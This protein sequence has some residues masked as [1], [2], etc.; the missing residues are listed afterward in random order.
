MF[1]SWM[2]PR[3]IE[4]RKL[5][6][7]SDD[8]GTAVNVQAMV[9][10]NMGEDSGTGVLFTR[11]PSTGA[12]RDGRVPDQRAGRRRGRR[13]SHSDVARQDDG[14]AFERGARGG[15]S[16]RHNL[17]CLWP[18]IRQQL[19]LISA[20]LEKAYK[21]MVD[22]EFTVQ[23]GELFIL[24]SR[25]GKRSARAAFKIAVDLVGEGV[26][27]RKTALTRLTADQFK[28]VRRPMIDPAFKEKPH[29]TGL[30]ACPGV[31]VGRPVFCAKEAVEAT[32]PVHPGDP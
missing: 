14:P 2:N 3:A 11:N 30:P 15:Q 12:N 9:F 23:K 10:G 21:D 24:Q 17:W 20:K 4:Y 25:H 18:G 1:D 5:N 27:D 32:D 6:K 13:H 7:L 16:G 19:V 22:L 28:A 29:F 26:I 31:A 8:M